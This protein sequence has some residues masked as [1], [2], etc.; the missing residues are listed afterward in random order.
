MTEVP[1]VIECARLKLRHLGLHDAPFILQLLN[2]AGFLRFIGDE[3]IGLRAAEMIRPTDGG[4][5]PKLFGPAF[6]GPSPG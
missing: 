2:E 3:K 5:G 6:I 4:P 1:Y